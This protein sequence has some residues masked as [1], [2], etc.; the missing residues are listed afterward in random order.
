MLWGRDR[1]EAPVETPSPVPRPSPAPAAPRPGAAASAARH[2]E[3]APSIL[4]SRDHRILETNAAYRARYGDGVVPGQTR[5]FQASHGYARPCNL[6]GETCPA[7]AC[8]AT[9]RP[10]RVVHRHRHGDREEVCDITLQPLTDAEGRVQHFLEIVRPHAPAPADWR[11]GLIG[12][13]PAFLAMLD[14]VAAVAPP[15]VPVLLLG[16]TGTGKER[17]AEAVHRGSARAGGPFVAVECP[18]IQ[19]SLFESELFGHERGAFTGADRR[20]EGLVDAARGGT[21]FLDEV[22]ELSLATQVRLLR[23]L[24]AGT[25]RRVGGTEPL[26]ADFRLVAATHR[27]LASMVA[28][29]RFRADLYD[30]LAVFPVALPP[31]RARPGDVALLADHL[32]AGRGPLTAGARAR[33]ASQPWPGNVRELRNVLERA[34]VLARGGPIPA[35]LIAGPSGAAAA[36]A[37]GTTPTSGPTFVS[38]GLQTLAAVEAAYLAWAAALPA[39]TRRELAERLGLSERQLYRRLRGH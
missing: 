4:L 5:C 19:E 26:R 7:Q 23:L 9:G 35:A 6:E 31:L 11:A 17:V 38:T 18:S 15:E 36:L 12:R 2:A 22:G 10:A 21:L 32:L 30:R 39:L 3:D 25:Y 24:E 14:T 16:E 37:P 1:L 33:L 34:C 8:L 28:A 29:G 27:D 20:R 13:A